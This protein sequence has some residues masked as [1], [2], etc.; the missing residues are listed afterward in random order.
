MV[1]SYPFMYQNGNK[2]SRTMVTT[3]NSEIIQKAGYSAVTHEEATKAW[4]SMGISKPSFGTMPSHASLQKFGQALHA[5][6]VLY[7]SVSWHTRS[8]WVNVGPKTISTATVNVYVFD[9][10]SGKVEYQ[11]KGVEGRSDEKSNNLKLVADVFL[12]PL[13]TAVSGGPATPREQRA[14]QIALGRAF[15]TWVHPGM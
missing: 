13:F 1:V 8:I 11:K 12:T 9:V 5:S 7:G 15:H 10:A 14:V 3:L 2:T 6:K 4:K